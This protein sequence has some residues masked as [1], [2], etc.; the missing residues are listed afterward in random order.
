MKKQKRLKN[1]FGITQPTDMIKWALI[2]IHS[3]YVTA[4]DVIANQLHIKIRNNTVT[5]IVNVI[6][7]SLITAYLTPGLLTNENRSIVDNLASLRNDKSYADLIEYLQEP[8]KGYLALQERSLITGSKTC[9][10]RLKWC[11]TRH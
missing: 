6:D 2:Q 8:L 11:L 7:H 9:C 10:L 1:R 5:L 3:E 4:V